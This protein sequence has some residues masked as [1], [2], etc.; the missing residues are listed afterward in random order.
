LLHIGGSA[1]VVA[2]GQGL[3]AL[4]CVLAVPIEIRPHD[5]V[6]DL[7]ELGADDTRVE[8]QIA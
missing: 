3:E 6:G 4:T 5:G 8:A 2:G 7:V 1:G